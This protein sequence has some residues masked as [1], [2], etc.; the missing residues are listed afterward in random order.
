[1]AVSMFAE[2]LVF[3]TVSLRSL[4][5]SK[6]PLCYNTSTRPSFLRTP[7]PRR[8]SKVHDYHNLLLTS[9]GNI[10]KAGRRIKFAPRKSLLILQTLSELEI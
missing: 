1:M 2:K 4:D 10:R 8:V 9:M 3:Y 7:Y 5:L 6:A